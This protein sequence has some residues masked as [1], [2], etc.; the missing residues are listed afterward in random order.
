MYLSDLIK[1]E[2]YTIYLGMKKNYI[3]FPTT[4][5]KVL[6]NLN[7]FFSIFFHAINKLHIVGENLKVRTVILRFTLPNFLFPLTSICVNLIPKKGNVNRGITVNSYN[8][9]KFVV[10]NIHT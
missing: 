8:F 1:K 9:F 6:L 10:K 5:R 3:Q 7:S 2:N 4:S